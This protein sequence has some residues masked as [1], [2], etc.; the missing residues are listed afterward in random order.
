MPNFHRLEH[1]GYSIKPHQLANPR[2]WGN[3]L[4]SQVVAPTSENASNSFNPLDW[5]IP[6][7]DKVVKVAKSYKEVFQ[8]PRSGEYPSKGET[9]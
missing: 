2:D 4:R 1:V 6:F 9:I 3:T 8:S 7:E 5:G